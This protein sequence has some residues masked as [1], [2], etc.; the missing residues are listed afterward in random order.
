MPLDA[1]VLQEDHLVEHLLDIRDEVG[2]DDDGG[3]LVVVADDGAENVVA[4]GGVHAADRLIEQI[5]LRRAGHD[6]DQLELFAR[7]LGER[8][9]ALGDVEAEALDHLLRRVAAEV[10]VEV[11]I[12]VDGLRDGHPVGQGVAVGEIGDDGLRLR[13][14]GFAVDQ[15]FAARGGEQTVGELDEGRFAAAVWAEQTD[16]AARLDGKL[17][18]LEGGFAAVALGERLTF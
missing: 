2:G 1:A 8:F 14:G 5:Q 11:G 10:G 6:E 17:H 4:G 3:V 13:R 15:N 18:A 7:A 9:D 12:V 16:D